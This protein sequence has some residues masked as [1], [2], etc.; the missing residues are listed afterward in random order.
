MKLL[1]NYGIAEQI[2]ECDIEKYG[3]HKQKM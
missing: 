2:L 3:K 1:I